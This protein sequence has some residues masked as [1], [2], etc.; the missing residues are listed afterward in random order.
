MHLSISTVRSTDA[1]DVLPLSETT[2]WNRV[3]R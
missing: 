1:L 2:L 3:V